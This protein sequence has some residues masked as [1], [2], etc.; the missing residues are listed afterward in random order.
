MINIS[1]SFFNISTEFVQTFCAVCQQSSKC[2]MQ[3][4]TI[5]VA[6]QATDIQLIAPGYLVQNSAH[7]AFSYTKGILLVS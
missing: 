6:V 1:V 4:K 7:L 2:L 3:K 5:L